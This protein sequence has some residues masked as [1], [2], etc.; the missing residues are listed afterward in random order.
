[1]LLLRKVRRHLVKNGVIK[2][3]GSVKDCCMK[4]ELEKSFEHIPRVVEVINDLKISLVGVTSASVGKSLN[5][6][7]NSTTGGIIGE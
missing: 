2:L 4:R 3:I 5:G 7:F 1:M 6:G